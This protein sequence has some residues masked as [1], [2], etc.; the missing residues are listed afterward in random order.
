MHLT[1]LSRM[2][3]R[4]LASEYAMCLISGPVKTLEDHN[5]YGDPCID[6]PGTLQ[7]CL[8]DQTHQRLIFFSL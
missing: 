5:G 7:I 4:H 3:S 8:A 2:P 6:L 1:K